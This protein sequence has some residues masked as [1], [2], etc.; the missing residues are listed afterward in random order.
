[1]TGGNHRPVS[2]AKDELT[3][4]K[5][6]SGKDALALGTGFLDRDVADHSHTS[7]AGPSQQHPHPAPFAAQGPSDVVA[8]SDSSSFVLLFEHSSD[9]GNDLR[10]GAGQRQTVPVSKLIL[11]RQASIEEE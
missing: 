3:L 6:S 9:D 1:M 4:A 5:V 10:A 2:P 7:D 11:D 8:R